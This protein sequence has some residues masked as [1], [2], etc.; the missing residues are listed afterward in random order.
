MRNYH[1]YPLVLTLL[2]FTIIVVV[3][4]YPCLRYAMYRLWFGA[5]RQ[6]TGMRNVTV[7]DI[8]DE[9]RRDKNARTAKEVGYL[10]EI[11]EEEGSEGDGEG[12]DNFTTRVPGGSSSWLS[13]PHFTGSIISAAGTQPK[14]GHYPPDSNSRRNRSAFSWSHYYPRRSRPNSRAASPS[15]LQPHPS[16]QDIRLVQ[17]PSASPNVVGMIHSSTEPLQRRLTSSVLSPRQLFAQT[18]ELPQLELSRAPATGLSTADDGTTLNMQ[19]LMVRPTPLRPMVGTGQT[20]Y[21]PSV[22]SL[23]GFAS[24]IHEQLSL[25]FPIPQHPHMQQQIQQG[26]QSSPSSMMEVLQLPPL[27]KTLS[28]NVSNRN[29]FYPLDLDAGA[30][31]VLNTA[32]PFDPTNPAHHSFFHNPRYNPQY[33][34]T[35]NVGKA[36]RPFSSSTPSYVPYRHRRRPSNESQHGEQTDMNNNSRTNSKT[37]GNAPGAHVQAERQRLNQ[38]PPSIPTLP[39][40]RAHSNQQQQQ[41]QQQQKP[42]QLSLQ[43]SERQYIN[44]QDMDED[45]LY[46]VAIAS[47]LDSLDHDHPQGT[48]KAQHARPSRHANQHHSPTRDQKSKASGGRRRIQSAGS[49]NF[50]AHHHHHHHQPRSRHGS[51]YQ[52]HINNRIGYRRSRQEILSSAAQRRAAAQRRHSAPHAHFRKGGGDSGGVDREEE[53]EQAEGFAYDSGEE[54]NDEDGVGSFVSESSSR[55]R[56]PVY[57]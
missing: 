13:T 50:P 34:A 18:G 39:I 36:G 35:A 51:V 32:Q 11:D 22:S 5:Y 56:H 55:P 26:S 10:Y 6:P 54:G 28:A 53:D 15:L 47:V 19:G 31:A 24:S 4:L 1:Y 44:S 43:D 48:S 29:S 3:M 45:D 9:A 17:S 25:P 12:K 52:N 16:Q 49:S 37:S 7:Y 33:L 38:Q 2:F 30:P 23:P 41:Q 40:G 20:L 27:A 46:S 14:P 42:Q 8:D 57:L 21:A